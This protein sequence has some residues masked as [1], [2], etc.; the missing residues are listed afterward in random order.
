[1]T[2]KDNEFS[3]QLERS[4]SMRV[5]GSL[6]TGSFSG[7][8]LVGALFT[9]GLVFMTSQKFN[10][11]SISFFIGFIFP[12]LYLMHTR[13][14]RK[15]KELMKPWCN[16][17]IENKIL[18][19]KTGFPNT[20]EIGWQEISINVETQNFT[21]KGSEVGGYHLRLSGSEIVRLGLWLNLS[22]AQEAASRLANL[23]GGVVSEDIKMEKD[24]S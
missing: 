22:D 11:L 24:N 1:M 14:V 10:I 2:K 21:I 16:I 19:Y 4:P 18:H 13:I 8:I 5:L 3:F 15:G 9:I 12:M 7:Q 23:T 17:K 20:M 6:W